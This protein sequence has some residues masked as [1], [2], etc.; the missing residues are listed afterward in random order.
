MYIRQVISI[1]I[2]L[3]LLNSCKV[4]HEPI[5]VIKTESGNIYVKLYSEK[6]PVTVNNFLK[7]VDKNRFLNSSFYRTVRT[8]NQPDN[9]VKIDV[10]QGG[11]FDD[12]DSLM[13]PPIKH[14]TTKET[15]IKHLNGTISMARN[16][17][18]TATSE[19]FICIGKQPELDYGGKRNP[20]GK[21]FAAFG[22]VIKGMNVV[23]KIQYSNAEGQW[24][25]PKIKIYDIVRK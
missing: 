11:L 22:K 5:V 20:D 13:L 16:E 1:F 6:A 24:L 10:I 12:D 23:K 8:D 25:K 4:K 21:G 7:Y 9:N 17:P 3:L 2:F 14:E 18:G 19:F 15:G